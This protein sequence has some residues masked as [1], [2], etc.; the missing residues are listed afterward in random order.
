[1]KITKKDVDIQLEI[2]NENAKKKYALS[3][4]NPDTWVRNSLYSGE[5]KEIGDTGKYYLSHDYSIGGYVLTTREMYFALKV[6]NDILRNEV[7][8]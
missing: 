3:R 7:R 4:N 5:P 2:L 6:V 1:V 8:G